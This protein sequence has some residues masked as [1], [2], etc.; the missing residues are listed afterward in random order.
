MNF[1]KL[2]VALMIILTPLLNGCGSKDTPIELPGPKIPEE[3]EEKKEEDNPEK[4]EETHEWDANRGKVVTPSGDGWTSTTISDGVVYYTFNGTDAISGKHQEVFAVD[5]DLSKTNYQVKLVY[6][7]PRAVAS[8]IQKKYNAV[9]TLNANYE[10]GSIYMRYNGSD[11]TM[12]PNT[13]IG[14]TGVP[15]WKSEAAFWCDGNGKMGIV[16]AGSAKR[17]GAITDIAGGTVADAVT[18]QRRYYMSR[19][20]TD[21]PSFCTSAPM[22]V[23]DYEPMGENFCDYTITAAEVN[24]LN[25]EDPERHQ[26][27]R[28]PRSAVAIT[29]NG[30]F[31]MF[32][33]DGRIKSAGMSARELTKFLVKWFNPQ[34][35]INMDGGGSTTL[36]VE[37]QGD[38]QTHVVNYPTD[39]NTYDHAG[40]RAR[41]MFFVLVRK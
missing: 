36:C 23:N 2:F 33:V 10:L 31:I 24:K 8:E 22:L 18:R 9:A 5:Y 27:V 20:K 1:R 19:S 16:F 14:D 11:V 38:S 3:Q 13:T 17:N 39:N 12:L 34:Y 41:D 25:G 6:C 4:P 37:G 26:R 40:E 30:H 29:E 28:H 21:Y 15:N 35:A 7:S 32:A